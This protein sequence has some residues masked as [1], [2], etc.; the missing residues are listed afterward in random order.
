MTAPA[1]QRPGATTILTPK[2]EPIHTGVEPTPA[3]NE[4]QSVATPT[5]PTPPSPSPTT[6]SPSA[7]ET[8]DR[9]FKLRK[10]GVKQAETVV[11]RR[12]GGYTSMRAFIDGA[13]AN[14]LA[15][16]AEAENGG[17]PF[18]PNGDVFTR[19]RPLGS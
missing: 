9:T 3:P 6:T 15:R 11:L 7:D 18:E 8:I 2:V 14:E 1:R 10:L 13:I 5:K 12:V 17:V 19:G 16:L 4:A